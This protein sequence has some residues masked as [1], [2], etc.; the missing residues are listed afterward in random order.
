M[1]IRGF[2][3]GICLAIAAALTTAVA[4]GAVNVLQVEGG[5]DQYAPV[6]FNGAT[7]LTSVPEGVT[8]HA[9]SGTVS[10]YS[11]HAATVKNRLLAADGSA[12]PVTDIYCLN[13]GDFLDNYVKTSSPSSAAPRP[14]AVGYDIKVVNQSWVGSYEDTAADLDAVRRMDYMIRRE[15]LVMTCGAVSPW[16]SPLAPTPLVWASR[17]GIAVR[18]TQTFTPSDA[19]SIGKVHADLWGPKTGSGSDEAS[20]YETPG[21]AGYAAALIDVADSNGWDNGLNGLRHEVV[22]SILMTGADK[23]AFTTNGFISWT[24]NGVN[25]LDNL[26]GAGRAD[27]DASLAVL[28]GGPKTMATVTGNTVNAPVVTTAMAGWWYEDS[29]SAYGDQALVLDLT[30]D[31]LTDL[32]ATLVWDVTQQEKSGNRLDTTTNGEVF[33]DLDLELLPVTYDGGTYTLGSSLGYSGLVSQSPDDNVEHLYF[34]DSLD[35]GFYAFVV[36]NNSDFAWD[37]GFSYGFTAV[38]EPGTLGLLI[39]LLASIC[40]L[41]RARRF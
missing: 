12:N 11:S 36:S 9:L 23:A 6:N 18:G 7:S 20:S 13:A 33:A 30:D 8:Y 25:N 19:N 14:D 28:T 3:W 1:I 32:T 22:K 26:N 38:P 21:V 31:M 10:T 40:C 41:R 29:L 4:Y 2:C 35:P 27:Y 37:Y 34:T 24:N 39:S 15:D 17:N 5:G 16:G